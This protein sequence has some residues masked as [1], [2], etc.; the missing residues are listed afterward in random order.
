[1]QCVTTIVPYQTFNT[2][3]KRRWRGKLGGA[4]VVVA[5]RALGAPTPRQHAR[6]GA[7]AA[8]VVDEEEE[9]DEEDELEGGRRLMRRAKKR[10]CGRA[11]PGATGL[12]CS[13]LQ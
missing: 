11:P 8:G 10:D 12:C 2:E 4:T 6:D 3:P 13:E 7:A 9:E 1:L 5:G